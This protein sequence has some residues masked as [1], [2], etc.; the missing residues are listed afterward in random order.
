MPFLRETAN[1]FYPSASL[2]KLCNGWFIE[3]G[4]D[5]QMLIQKGRKLLDAHGFRDVSLEVLL[6]DGTTK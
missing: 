6:D 3:V 4:D 5:Q 2:K 1:G